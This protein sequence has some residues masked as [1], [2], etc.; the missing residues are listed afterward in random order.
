MTV[1]FD[2][3]VLVA[4]LI[5]KGLCHEAFHRAVRL[6]VLA[7]SVPLMDELEATLRRKFVVSPTVAAFLAGFREQIRIV[8]PAALP[9]PVCRDP[10][11]DMVLATAVAAAAD[12]IVTGDQDLLVLGNYQA[13]QI[14]SPRK[15]IELL[16]P[17]G[18][19]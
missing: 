10:D 11:D 13:I 18:P 19:S 12:L 3:N 8:E 17:S 16:D 5:A 7:S 6:R 15:F 1:V 2:A 14:V 4:A 9:M